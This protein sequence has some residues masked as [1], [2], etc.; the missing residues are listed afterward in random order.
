MDIRP[1][2]LP[3]LRAEMTLFE[4]GRDR[5]DNR[6]DVAKGLSGAELFWA[7][8]AMVELGAAASASLPSFVVNEQDLPALDGLLTFES[9]ILVD[10]K[11]GGGGRR[12]CRIQGVFWMTFR[13]GCFIIWPLLV[14]NDVGSTVSPHA[15]LPLLALP[16]AL[17]RNA[18]LID[19]GSAA[20]WADRISGSEAGWETVA[21]LLL[22]MWLLMQQQLAEVQTVEPDRATRKRLQRAGHEPASV[23]VIELRRPKH[24]GSDAGESGREYQHQWI[25]R[26]HW[27]NHWHPKREVH[28]P[29][30]IAPHVKGP[31]GAPMIG[32]EKVYAWKR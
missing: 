17:P 2:D 7:S 5:D 14:R 19:F 21:P 11:N 24:A 27:R 8:S 4:D 9:P 13:Q 22:S 15:G 26:G 25:V 10:Q 1:Q 23:R 6:V 31:E 29:V 32:G 28:R 12:Q 30:W 3:E 20:W 18:L 16:K